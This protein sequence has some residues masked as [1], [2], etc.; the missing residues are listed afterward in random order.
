M[1]SLFRE[2]KMIT[3]ETDLVSVMREK[4]SSCLN[5][6][7]I[8][9]WEDVY[10]EMPLMEQASNSY[11]KEKFNSLTES[12]FLADHLLD[13]KIE[14]FFHDHE[15]CQS[16]EFSGKK[17]NFKSGLEYDDWQL[18]LEIIAIKY[19][20]NWNVKNPFCSFYGELFGHKFRFSLIHASTSPQ[21][22][23]KLFL[24]R[25]STTPHPL[26]SFGG[27]EELTNLI[28]SKKNI[29]IAGSTGSGKTS[30]LNSL[31]QTINSNEHLVILEDTY[32]IN[33]DNPHETRFLAGNSEATSLKAYLSYCLRLSPDRIIL[34]EMRSD[35][36]IPFL[37]A[38][39]T[40][41]KG[42]MGTIHASG[43]VDAIYRMALLFSIYS[44]NASLEYPKVIDM[45]CRNLEFVVF[46]ENKKI[47]QIIRIL[48]SDK[49][50][51]FFELY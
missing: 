6:G 39:N 32:E 5:K 44:K 11:L 18:W 27:G 16:V 36:V 10:Q 24:R 15:D 17:L 41:H 48:G 30:L 51:P 4:L 1:L 20:Q 45:I 34:G 13:P 3:N 2:E 14:Y 43:A 46:M 40:G 33:T 19:K 31:L 25:L 42:L 8:P 22:K 26:S 28:A 47:H 7:S 12:T 49:G 37:M 21:N 23:S 9:S 29:L 35:E 38:M 50:V